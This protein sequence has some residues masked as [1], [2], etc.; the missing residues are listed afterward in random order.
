MTTDADVQ[1][2]S[3]AGG[4]FFAAF[5]ERGGRMSAEE[6]R[7]QADE[8]EYDLRV[9]G[10]YIR[11]KWL[12][13]DDDDNVFFTQKTWRWLAGIYLAQRPGAKDGP[14][15]LDAEVRPAEAR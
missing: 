5:I 3:K 15:A 11:D 12:V 10:P 9:L 14:E 8:C 6:T 7:K 13:K 4:C 2:R 1:R